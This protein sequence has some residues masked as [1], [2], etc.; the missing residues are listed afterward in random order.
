MSHPHS[1]ALPVAAP[2]NRETWTAIPA[3]EWRRR[4]RKARAIAA[5]QLA[6]CGLDLDCCEND[7]AGQMTYCGNIGELLKP[8]VAVERDAL[9]TL[10]AVAQTRG[11]ELHTLDDTLTAYTIAVA[12]AA[13]LFGVISGC[14]LPWDVIEATP[15]PYEPPKANKGGA[16]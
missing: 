12:E 11:E 8:A 3:A 16:R 1:S 13:Y 5:A 2:T 4:L 14:Q 15:A 9:D 7:V 6:E 10:V